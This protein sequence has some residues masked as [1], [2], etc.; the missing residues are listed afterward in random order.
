QRDGCIRRTKLAYQQSGH[1]H[2]VVDSATVQPSFALAV[3]ALVEREGRDPERDRGARKIVVVLLARAS[4]VEHDHA[5]GHRATGI[6]G[7]PEGVGGPIWAPPPGW[8]DRHDGPARRHRS[9]PSRATPY[10]FQS[11]AHAARHPALA[12]A[13]AWNAGQRAWTARARGV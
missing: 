1:R 13:P 5:G 4:T 6:V 2:H 3:A 12:P 9:A 8:P 7:Q 11:C 10:L